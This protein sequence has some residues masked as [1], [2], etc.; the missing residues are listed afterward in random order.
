MEQRAPVDARAEKY[1]AAAKKRKACHYGINKNRVYADSRVNL[2]RICVFS[3]QN[4]WGVHSF[5]PLGNVCTLVLHYTLLWAGLFRLCCTFVT[6]ISEFNSS[7]EAGLLV[8]CRLELDS[9]FIAPK[10]VC[11]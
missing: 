3:G 11:Y 2:S 8:R 9:S 7:T 4:G 5:E 6:E 10:F 1:Q